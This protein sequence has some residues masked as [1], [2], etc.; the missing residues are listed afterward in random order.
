[1]STLFYEA[2]R[3]WRALPPVSGGSRHVLPE[4]NQVGVDKMQLAKLRRARRN[5]FFLSCLAPYHEAQRNDD[6][7]A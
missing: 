2:L 3:S 5:H 7:E 4:F 6:C 1:M